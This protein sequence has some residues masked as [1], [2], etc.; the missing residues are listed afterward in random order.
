ME[1]RVLSGPQAGCRLPLGASTYRAGGGDACDVV[2]E[3]MPAD[4]IA[5][6]IYVGQRAI[7]LEALSDQVR[8]GG[9]AVS[10]LI[11]LTPGQVFEFGQWLFAVDDQEAPWPENP[12]AQSA[13][14]PDTHEDAIAPTTQAADVLATPAVTIVAEPSAN[15]VTT[16]KSSRRPLPFWIIGLAATAAFLVCGVLVLTMSL[17]PTPS[18]AAATPPRPVTD[19]LA[20][21]VA[22]AGADIKVDKL[23]GERFRLTGSVATREQKVALTR[24]ARAI[25]PGVMIQVNADEDLEALARDAL[26]LFPQ[27]GVEMQ[28]LRDGKLVIAGTL[29]EAKVRDQIVAA[30]WDGVPGLKS[31]DAQ[32]LADDEVLTELATQLT[33]ANLSNRLAGAFDPA[34]LAQLIVQGA[35]DDA[36]R[37]T[38]A[39]VREH[40]QARFGSRLDIVEKFRAQGT[41]SLPVKATDSDVVAIVRGP[42]PYALLRDGSKRPLSTTHDK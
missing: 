36:A 33:Q 13:T 40:L 25:A 26:S 8:V 32:V 27:S 6:V 19:Q 4:Q 16:A 34:N 31:I 28:S 39:T 7:G 12:S 23:E 1:L 10:Q 2:L 37:A 41:V 42:I 38:W 30:L 17:A 5:F 9:R 21:L 35:L 11:A 3:G 22:R 15:A 18:V 29:K 20:A 14:A 24:D